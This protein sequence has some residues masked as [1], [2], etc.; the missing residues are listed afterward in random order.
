MFIN[1]GTAIKG[2]ME[3][4]REAVSDITI[5][6]S[7]PSLFI[8]F[9]A[10]S[11]TCEILTLFRIHGFANRA[12]HR[13]NDYFICKFYACVIVDLNLVAQTL[14]LSFKRESFDKQ[15]ALFT[16]VTNR[17]FSANRVVPAKDIVFVIR[18]RV[19]VPI[20]RHYNRESLHLRLCGRA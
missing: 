7:V 6:D 2:V 1:T 17:N 4:Y 16:C 14:F 10:F 3:P 9:I 18:L 8:S 13:L 11:N 15:Y 5:N 19:N 12:L 20:I